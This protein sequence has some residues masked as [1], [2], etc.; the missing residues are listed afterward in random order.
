MDEQLSVE[1]Q[2]A[3]ARQGYQHMREHGWEKW[4]Y[5]L[6]QSH[7]EYVLAGVT[8]EDIPVLLAMPEGPASCRIFIPTVWDRIRVVLEDVLRGV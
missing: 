4:G 7:V 8:L 1:L 3:F 2:R 6:F 5:M